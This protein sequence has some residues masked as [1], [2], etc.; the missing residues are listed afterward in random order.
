MS[1]W[2]LESCKSRPSGLFVGSA[3]STKS[4]RCFMIHACVSLTLQCSRTERPRR[5]TFEA[6]AEHYVSRCAVVRHQ[7][8][9][10]DEKSIQQTKDQATNW[11]DS[12]VWHV[13]FKK[14]LWKIES[15]PA[16]GWSKV[17]DCRKQ[18]GG[19]QPHPK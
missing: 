5:I 17:E 3:K 2:L 4:V 16:A 11:M 7:G 18:A 14:A 13:R 9:T 8:Y 12:Q 10:S 19:R 15:R 6:V 1:T